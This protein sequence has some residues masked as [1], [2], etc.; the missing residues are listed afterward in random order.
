M[1]ARGMFHSGQTIKRGHDALVKEL[2]ESRGT[3]LTTISENLRIT[4]PNKID[5]G[6]TEKAVEW[7]RN[8]KEFLEAYYLE[9]MNAVVSSLQNKKMLDPYL[10]LSGAIELNEH[11]LRVE[12]AQEIEN[13]ISSRGATLYDRIKNQFLDRPLIVIGVITIVA[14]TAILAFL[15]LLG[16]FG[17]GS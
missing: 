2:V 12:L 14:V 11:E 4:K 13:Y 16:V 9:Q 10:N 3:I 6:L 17:N 5:P 1:N 15:N 8:R 7:L